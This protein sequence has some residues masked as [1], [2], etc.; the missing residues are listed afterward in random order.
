MFNRQTNSTK[1]EEQ[2]VNPK[3]VPRSNAT[4]PVKHKGTNLT[5][6]PGKSSTSSSSSRAITVKGIDTTK[7]HWTLR[8]VCDADKNVRIELDLESDAEKR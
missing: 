7:A 3:R 6:H 2:S 5:S 4:S 1:A 8:V